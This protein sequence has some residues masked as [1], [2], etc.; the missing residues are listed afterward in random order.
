MNSYLTRSW[1]LLLAGISGDV[2]QLPTGVAD[3]DLELLRGR[4]VC[5]SR[6]F[7]CVALVV[8]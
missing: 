3:D 4:V 5:F 8:L 2:R 1:F 6:R 7:L